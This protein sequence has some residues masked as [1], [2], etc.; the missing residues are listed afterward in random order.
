AADRLLQIGVRQIEQLLNAA[1][2]ADFELLVRRARSH[3]IGAKLDRDLDRRQACP[4]RGAENEDG[5]PRLHV[6]AILKPMQRRAV[7]NGD[8][9]S[10]FI[11]NAVRQRDGFAR[12]CD[13]LLAA[14]VK[15]RI[16]EYP[17][18][19][20]KPF[21]ARANAH[22]RAGNFAPWRKGQLGAVLVFSAHH[23]RVEKVERN[24]RYADRGLA[25]AGHRLRY[26]AHFKRVRSVKRLAQ[27]CFH[28]LPQWK[29]PQSTRKGA[30]MRGYFAIGAERISKPMNLGNLLRSAHAF[31]AKFFFTIG[32]HPKAF[33]ARSD[34]SKAPAHLPVYHWATASEMILPLKCKLVGVELIEGA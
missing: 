15:A 18:A 14:A 11:G 21:H 5:L 3:N 28:R 7:S 32:A 25:F 34:T 12:G 20:A 17:L 13:G 31:G 6:A 8:G 19:D 22:Y 4:A 33:E 26:L 1:L 2:A 9:G 24:G 29:R 10:G 30:C 16:G 27:N 23:Q